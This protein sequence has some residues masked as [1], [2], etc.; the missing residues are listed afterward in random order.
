[1]GKLRL[2]SVHLPPSYVELLEE[3]VKLGRFPSRSEAIR[4]AVRELILREYQ[5]G[6]RKEKRMW[7]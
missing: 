5:L 7:A 2:V 1:M 3:L 6:L 4:V